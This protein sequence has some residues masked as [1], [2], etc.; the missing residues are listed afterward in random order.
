MCC[1]IKR[2]MIDTSLPGAF[3]LDQAYFKSNVETTNFKVTSELLTKRLSLTRTGVGTSYKI[4]ELH[5]VK[6][7]VAPDVPSKVVSRLRAYVEKYKT[8]IDINIGPTDYTTT[9]PPAHIPVATSSGKASSAPGP[10]KKS[11]TRANAMK[12]KKTSM[13]KRR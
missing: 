6:L 11:K 12:V 4:S 13:K 7:T 9:D 3:Y 10:M 2:G 8:I 5:N 1:R